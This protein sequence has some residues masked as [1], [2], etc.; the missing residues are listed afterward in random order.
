MLAQSF[1]TAIELGLED[2]ELESLISVLGMLERGELKHVSF[3]DAALRTDEGFRDAVVGDCFNM[4]RPEINLS[5]GTIGCIAGW[6]RHISNGAAFG[7]AY[8]ACN[9]YHAGTREL[10]ELFAPKRNMDAIRPDQA[11]Q[12]LRS[13]LTTGK[14]HWK[15]ALA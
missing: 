12:A 15:E 2:I 4:A 14:A 11:A 9:F 3:P 1:K 7:W 5:C 8:N 13:F 6:A 10:C